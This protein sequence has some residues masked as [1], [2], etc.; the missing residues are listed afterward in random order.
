M[1]KGIPTHDTIA[2]VF[3]RLN[4]EQ[5]QKCFLSWI[6]SISCLNSG[7]VIALDGKT[8]RHSYDGRGNKK[9][10]HMVSAW[11]TS[12]RLVLGQVKVDKKSNEIAAI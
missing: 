9:A 10:I 3:S 1:P 12:Q 6:Q 8:L 11:A 7:E 2:R 4:S 5:F